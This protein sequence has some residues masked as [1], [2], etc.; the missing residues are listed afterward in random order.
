[1]SS[2]ECDMS[3]HPAPEEEERLTIPWLREQGVDPCVFR[4]GA[5]KGDMQL[6]RKAA[7][8]ASTLL[9]KL[10]SHGVYYVAQ[11]EALALHGQLDDVLECVAVAHSIVETF[12]S[13][14]NQKRIKKPI[15]SF[16]ASL[17]GEVHSMESMC[18]NYGLASALVLTMTFGN[19]AS[20]THEDWT[21]YLMRISINN[22]RCQLT[23][24]ELCPL[25][26]NPQEPIVNFV[27][28]QWT[29]KYCLDALNDLIDD[30]AINMTAAGHGC[31]L[32]TIVCAGTS[33]W[34]IELAFTLGNGGGTALL[35]LCVLFTSWLYISL[36]ASKANR[37]R[38][39]E[40][41]EIT[42]RLRREFL[43]LH[44][45]FILGILCSY[46]GMFAMM[47]TKVTTFW[48]S[49]L[50]TLILM[51]SWFMCV[52][53][54][55]SCLWKVFLI[56]RNV[57]SLRSNDDGQDWTAE[58][59]R[60]KLEEEQGGQAQAAPASPSRMQEPEVADITNQ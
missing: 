52:F 40:A 13:R 18:I 56:N 59:M 37:S 47:S 23:A 25:G 1:V 16:V 45:L 5:F 31:C 32:D 39:P 58:S 6:Q 9:D 26:D 34:N 21:S 29:P 36:N 33:S 43:I 60:Y 38:W 4:K 54:F 15:A 50:V 30:P 7:E 22:P 28:G 14:L 46:F 53:L 35:L 44:V 20:M 11:L 12:D 3:V 48:L 19:F 8:L 10:H 27:F 51:A 41:K 55:G 17:A 24:E 49:W 57:D 42:K 2:G